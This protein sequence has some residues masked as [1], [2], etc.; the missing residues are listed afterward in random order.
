MTTKASPW[1][2][3]GSATLAALLVAHP[4]PAAAEAGLHEARVRAAAAGAVRRPGMYLL[5]R[6]ARVAELLAAAGGPMAGAQLAGV[7]LAAP[8]ADGMRVE[9]AQASPRPWAWVASPAQASRP[10]ARRAAR[11]LRRAAQRPAK[12]APHS[13]VLNR[14]TSQELDRLPGV[15]PAMARRILEARAKAG[16]FR[17]LEDLREVKGLGVKRLA[18]IDPFVRLN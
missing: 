4:G 13:V 18:A 3:A 15:G 16:G 17:S 8:V 2:W 7:N 1:R 9:V 11:P 10:T 14:A 5:P 6:G 12:P